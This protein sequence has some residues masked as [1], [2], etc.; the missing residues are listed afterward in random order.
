MIPWR[1]RQLGGQRADPAAAS[2]AQRRCRRVVRNCHVVSSRHVVFEPAASAFSP[3]GVVPGSGVVSQSPDGRC[4]T[5]SV[6]VG[7]QSVTLSGDNCAVRAHCR[8]LRRLNRCLPITACGRHPSMLSCS[9][10]DNDTYC[11]ASQSLRGKRANAAP[12]QRQV[13]RSSHTD[14]SNGKCRRRPLPTIEKWI[15]QFVYISSAHLLLLM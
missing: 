14:G 9:V 10:R 4:R 6:V 2:T 5:R 7:A 11:P 1:R 8:E 15:F 3:V 12:A 13:T